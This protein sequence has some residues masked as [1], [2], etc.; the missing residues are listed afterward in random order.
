MMIKLRASER[1]AGR[2]PSRKSQPKNVTLVGPLHT[3]ESSS[4]I[5][6]RDEVFLCGLWFMIYASLY[7][8][9]SWDLLYRVN[10]VHLIVRDL[11]TD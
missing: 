9:A 6:S 4:I 7:N 8:T 5:Q 10:C 1:E 3:L 11:E 2:S